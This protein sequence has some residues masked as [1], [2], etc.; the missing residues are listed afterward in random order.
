MSNKDKK[1]GAGVQRC[2]LILTKEYRK[3]VLYSLFWPNIRVLTEVGEPLSRQLGTYNY[4]SLALDYASFAP[5]P[6]S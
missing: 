6:C 5:A 4:I 3:V 1:T 2:N